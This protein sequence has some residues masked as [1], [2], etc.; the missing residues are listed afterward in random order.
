MAFRL[1]ANVRLAKRTL[2]RCSF[3]M[4]RRSRVIFSPKI[5]SRRGLQ[6]EGSFDHIRWKLTI[7]D[8]GTFWHI[9]ETL[10]RH[11]FGKNAN[12]EFSFFLCN[13]AADGER[14]LMEIGFFP[15]N[16]TDTFF[17]LHIENGSKI[18]FC[19]NLKFTQRITDLRRVR[20]A[21][22]HI[23]PVKFLCQIRHFFCTKFRGFLAI[24]GQNSH[25]KIPKIIGCNLPH[26]DA[27]IDPSFV[28]FPSF[29]FSRFSGL[30]KNLHIF[31]LFRRVELWKSIFRIWVDG[32]RRLIAHSIGLDERN[33]KCPMM[34]FRILRFSTPFGHFSNFGGQRS[35]CAKNHNLCQKNLGP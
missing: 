27:S 19:E 6:N 13:R 2:K 1:K 30:R 34:I 33:K 32:F 4:E 5:F 26:R 28:F 25:F 9:G 35:C 24:R 15:W 10:A 23:F 8:F 21:I 7:F 20:F 12:F 29:W 22:N 18:E 3:A 17:G 14:C 11:N 31:R 16:V